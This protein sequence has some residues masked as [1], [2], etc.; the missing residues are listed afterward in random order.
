MPT[1]RDPSSNGTAPL[2]PTA[3]R[4]EPML[5]LTLAE[6]QELMRKVRQLPYEHAPV[7]EEILRFL[8]E[9]FNAQNPATPPATS[10]PHDKEA[11]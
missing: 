3:P 7:I 1:T 2:A 11:H 9:R 5:Q 8:A 4:E 6:T 10:Q